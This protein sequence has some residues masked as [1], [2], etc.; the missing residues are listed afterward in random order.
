MFRFE[1]FI[2]EYIK[3]KN[4]KVEQIQLW[5]KFLGKFAFHEAKKKIEQFAI[6]YNREPLHKRGG[7]GS[8]YFVC[9][10]LI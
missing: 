8:E 9:G 4:E 1:D 10:I 2:T 3:V 7:K 5:E 6:C